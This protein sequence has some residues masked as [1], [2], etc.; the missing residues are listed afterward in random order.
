MEKGI[1][2]SLEGGEGVGKS[3]QIEFIKKWFE[4]HNL[5]Y[6]CTKEPGG[7]PL[8]EQVRG[9][10]KYAK[11]EIVPRAELLLFNAARAE[12]IE[13][14]IRPAINNRINVISDRFF[15]ST[16]A[17]QAYGRGLD[18]NTVMD[19]CK[20]AT[21]Q[22]EPDI[23]FWL[24]LPPKEAFERKFGADKDDRMEQSGIEFH[25]RV[26]EG[27]KYLAKTYPNRIKRIDAS[28][29]AEEVSAQIDYYLTQK[30]L[31]KKL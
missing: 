5:K 14:V 1:F 6:L 3:T 21:D 8:G 4:D 17:Y 27:Y 7:T 20:Y 26:Y 25:N 9:I 2:I 13:E 23:T 30:F 11:F 18:V 31:T 10:L 15:D 28:K 12:L 24:D 19:I 22:I 29:S 16:I